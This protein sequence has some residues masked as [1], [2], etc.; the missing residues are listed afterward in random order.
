MNSWVVSLSA[1][2]FWHARSRGTRQRKA[3][4]A[5]LL[6][7]KCEASRVRASVAIRERSFKTAYEDFCCSNQEA[8]CGA[9]HS[10]TVPVVFSGQAAR[11]DPS[12]FLFGKGPQRNIATKPPLDKRCDGATEFQTADACTRPMDSQTLCMGESRRATKHLAGTNVSNDNLD[13]CHGLSREIN[14]ETPPQRIV[15]LLQGSRVCQALT[16]AQNTT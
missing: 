15:F 4:A 1:A 9:V 13:P 5:C 10:G 11:Q 16:G 7:G 12:A 2:G 8:S 6:R 3:H 14:H